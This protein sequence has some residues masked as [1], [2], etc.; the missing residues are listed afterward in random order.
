MKSNL[1]IFAQRWL[2]VLLLA[3]A[4]VA[5]E[6]PILER[7]EW[8]DIWVTNADK[9]DLPRVLLI[10]DSI[11]RQYFKTVEKALDGKANCARYATSKFIADP[12][13][14][15]ELEILLASYR[16]E[17][18]HINNGL[19]G[20]GYTEAQYEA[21]FPPLLKMLKKAAPQAK[22]IWAMTTPVRRRGDL[23]QMNEERTVRVR[24]RNRIAGAFAEQHGLR[25]DDLYAAVE[26]H[27]D[28]YQSGGTH[29]NES[30]VAAL[31]K[32][33]AASI[34]PLLPDASNALPN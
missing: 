10:G 31:G 5:A 26:A 34:L 13:F 22:L 32:Q 7:I 29:F 19:H 8:S 4:A 11:T 14:L 3:S 17:V 6:K 27:P 33:V 15:P 25:I 12:G 30:G 9:D 21:G 18:I 16:F 2:P 1:R 23:D 20:F 28:F 24:E